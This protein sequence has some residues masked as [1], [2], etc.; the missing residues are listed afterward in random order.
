M[1]NQ[2]VNTHFVQMRKKNYLKCYSVISTCFLQHVILISFAYNEI[3]VIM[4][5]ST[6]ATIGTGLDFVNCR[7][8]YSLIVA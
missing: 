7:F 8:L 3:H 6:M 5:L 2:A 1:S 4:K